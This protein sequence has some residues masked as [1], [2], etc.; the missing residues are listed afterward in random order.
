MIFTS[1]G[2][3]IDEV[4]FNDDLLKNINEK[5]EDEPNM[6]FKKFKENMAA[7]RIDEGPSNIAKLQ[8]RRMKNP[9]LDFLGHQYEFRPS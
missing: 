9:I 3:F 1:D 4:E 6:T 5:N 7:T 2:A 8:R